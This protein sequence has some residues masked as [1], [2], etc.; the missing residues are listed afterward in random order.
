MSRLTPQVQPFVFP[1]MVKDARSDQWT[2]AKAIMTTDT[3]PQQADCDRQ[4]SGDTDVTING[5]AM[6]RA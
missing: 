6:A 1:G 5:I 3:Y 2:E 4:A